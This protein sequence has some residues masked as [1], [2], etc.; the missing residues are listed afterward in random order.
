MKLTAAHLESKQ[1]LDP[2]TSPSPQCR[3][4]PVA[5]NQVEKPLPAVP[6]RSTA[7]SSTLTTDARAHLQRFILHALEEENVATDRENWANALRGVALQ[8]G[9]KISRGGWLAGFK[10]MRRK[11]SQRR[12][13]EEARLQREKVERDR[14]RE[15]EER[16][17]RN[18]TLPKTP[19]AR[20]EQD[21]SASDPGS[22]R[23]ARSVALQQL[24]E[25]VATHTMPPRPRPSTKHLLLTVEAFGAPP[26]RTSEDLEYDIIPYGVGCIFLANTYAL[27]DDVDGNEH[28]L[29]GLAEWDVEL[30]DAADKDCIQ[31]VGGTFTF[32]GVT[33]VQQHAS[34]VK[35]LRLSIFL[36]LSLLLEQHLL[37][38]SHV[39]LHSPK[40]LLPTTVIGTE[41]EPS[42]PTEDRIRPKRESTLAVA[43]GIWSF[44][45]KKTENLVH[46]VAS[47]GPSVVRRGSL[48]LPLTRSL[49]TRGSFDGTSPRPRRFSFISTSSSGALRSDADRTRQQ[50]FLD[51]LRNVEARKDL[52]STSPG[53][54]FQLPSVLVS[55]ADKEK[56]DPLRRLNGEERAALTSLLGWEG[57]DALGRGMVG[58]A[59][60]VR[61]QGISLL[62]S[63][64]VP[65]PLVS[66][67]QPPTPS[68]S[69]PT[70]SVITVPHRFTSCGNRRKWTTYRYYERGDRPDETLGETIARLC[71]MAEEQ[72][73]EPGCQ[74]LR[75]DHDLQ[76]IHAGVRIVATIG[77]PA[78]AD[79]KPKEDA[80]SIWQAC[81][82]CGEETARQQ[83]HD[84]S[85][86]SFG[87]YLELLI[88]SPALCGVTP[89]LC[90]HTALPPKSKDAP[91]P[92]TRLNILRKFS[93]R[94]RT[95]TFSLTTVE[96]IF[97]LK[98]PRLQIIRRRQSEKGADK[99]T[100][101]APAS[102]SKVTSSDDDRHIL[103]KEIMRWWQGLAEHIDK[104]E[105]NFIG[106][107]DTVRVKALP[108]L[109]S[110]DDAYDVTDEAGQATPKASLSRLPS[111][112]STPTVAVAREDSSTSTDSTMSTKT[113]TPA[114]PSAASSDSVITTSSKS[115]SVR[116][117]GDEM[118]LLTGLRHSFQRQEQNLYAELSRTPTTS[119]NN[120]ELASMSTVTPR[121]A[122]PT[123]PPP[124]PLETRSSFFAPGSSLK[125]FL[126]STTSLPD[127]DLDDAGWH[128][129]ETYS[130][131]ICRKEH[132]KDPTALLSIRDVLRHKPGMENPGSS[133]PRASSSSGTKSPAAARAKPAVE[134]SM[135]AADG[136]V[137]GI[138]EDVG[139]LLHDLDANTSVVQTWRT[140]G[141]S[142]SSASGFVETNIRR[143]KSDSI[144]STSSDATTTSTESGGAGR[145]LSPPLLPP[146][147]A[148]MSTDSLARFRTQGEP[149]TPGSTP[150]SFIPSITNTLTSAMKYMLNTGD[151][152]RSAPA[153]P[154]HGLLST[155]SP[156]IDERPH[157]KYDW[158]IGKRL[159]FSCT[160]YY[161]RQFDSL[162]R[163]CGIEDTFLK[164]LMRS[165]NWAAD[166]G[167][168]KSNFWK[169]SDDQF[170]IKTLVNAWNVADLQVLID[171]GPSYFRY[172]DSTATKPSVLAKLLGFYTIEIRNLETGTV[173]ARADL[174]VME[175]LFYAQKIS[176]TFDLKGIQGRKVKASNTAS[177]TLF[178]GEWIEDQRRTLTLVHPHSKVLFQEAVKADCDFLARTNIMDYSLL[179][180]IDEE[181]KRIA[182]G[183][184]DT[185]GSYTFAKTLEYKAK[186]NLNAGKEVTVV[187]PHEYQE[188]FV[189]A[190]DEYFLAC[191]D[192]WSRPLDDT[193]VPHSHLDLPSVL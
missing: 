152:H 62:Y 121:P 60:F 49:S 41:G 159:K 77:L 54:V 157:I 43:G 38:N 71:S 167:K 75:G 53:L 188:R 111:S 31:I 129:P 82:V 182:C 106:E 70:S 88:Y 135:Q 7:I 86:F 113:I 178:D 2:K 155:D 26:K 161:A 187:P 23:H 93:C 39:E 136:H 78:N 81:A 173:Q 73:T 68:G 174:L 90:A 63:A 65:L 87:K 61:Q 20:E 46:R 22:S 147:D 13:E 52:V 95:V 115:Q 107:G 11:A 143:G 181:R 166:G 120:R 44:F 24:R 9:L 66:S 123:A 3:L 5:M 64:H 25:L 130:A 59:G 165:A 158:T 177:K 76:W 146:K 156:A 40:S 164:S 134:L 142:D 133:S 69:V 108:R 175:N 50:P 17:A 139:K 1:A 12:K 67:S 33:N 168:S 91:L 149:S 32:K 80:I 101:S 169:T 180:G 4:E 184:V 116:S 47:V 138:N 127:P 74:F 172:M 171:L 189:N 163:R 105:E 183:L 35:V 132:P 79:D 191:P 140:S 192:K 153:A 10:R 148:S 37:S 185:I 125:R 109:P 190:M 45:S 42:T 34:L 55:L 160:V 83:M 99:D 119:L 151:A 15:Q 28:I 18:K 98:V 51:T 102:P 128:E 170:I 48:E 150:S 112:A 124:T 84:G 137:S 97:E 8:L 186:Q 89:R 103:R 118:Q 27:P 122:L 56:E 30:Y 126:A 193:R 104:L 94:S 117:E 19:K 14:A 162:R 176:K 6:T 96:D 145:S 72:C 58:T 21:Q 154:H 114:Q 16:E 85:L 29:Y 144:I 57:K 100:A 36:Y 141:S 179:L 110:D 131:V 92:S